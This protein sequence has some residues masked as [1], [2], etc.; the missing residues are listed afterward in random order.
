MLS[1]P[2]SLKLTMLNEGPFPCDVCHQRCHSLT[3]LQTHILL[4][5]AKNKLIC[6]ICS[7]IFASATNMRNHLATH[8]DQKRFKCRYCDRRFNWRTQLTTHEYTH[9]GKGLYYCPLC[10]KPCMTKWLLT[11]HL[12]VHAKE[13][14][15]RVED[16]MK[17]E[18]QRTPSS[19][20]LPSYPTSDGSASPGQP[21]GGA[22][23]PEPESPFRCSDCGASC[24]SQEALAAHLVAHLNST[25][26]VCKGC[27]K[28]YHKLAALRAHSRRNPECG[29]HNAKG[30][31]NFVPS[32]TSD[33]DP[34]RYSPPEPQPPSTPTYMSVSPVT[35]APLLPAPFSIQALTAKPLVTSPPAPL[36]PDF[37]KTP[38][39]DHI[40]I[41]QEHQPETPQG[42]VKD[43][44]RS[45]DSPRS[46]EKPTSRKRSMTEE[47][48][49]SYTHGM[50]TEMAKRPRL[51]PDVNLLNAYPTAQ[52]QAID[53]SVRSSPEV[54]HSHDLPAAT[55]LHM[56]PCT[57]RSPADSSP[58][59]EPSPSAFQLKLLRAL[60]SQYHTLMT[61]LRLHHEQQMAHQTNQ[62]MQ[63]Q[64]Q[65]TDM[66]EN[67]RILMAKLDE[68]VSATERSLRQAAI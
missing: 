10:S 56:T 26:H 48:S 11:R 65:L 38:S 36:A 20:D 57:T 16:L 66:K 21:E 39:P 68:R 23:G 34:A 45:P 50:P 44:Q 18:F 3:E 47:T 62:V 35:V 41:K 33:R 27:N 59:P 29:I 7:K 43:V 25:T 8:V 17:T 22:M 14:N 53:L 67:N 12:K 37:T 5:S 49:A 1:F 4:H 54:P 46:S 19:P 28:V 32:E 9:N 6:P 55:S 58:T 63:L 24:V 61:Q 13:T 42:A 52:D 2:C 31:E 51:S 40:V 64:R 60:D 15:I 30:I